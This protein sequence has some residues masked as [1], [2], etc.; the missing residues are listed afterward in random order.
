M[1][2]E[3]EM[4]MLQAKIQAG[5]VKEE[6]VGNASRFNDASAKHP[7]LPHF[8]DGID[9]LDIW[10]TRFERPDTEI[11]CDQPRRVFQNNARPKMEPVRLI[12]PEKKLN[13]GQRTGKAKVGVADKRLCFK[14]KKTGH[15]A[16]YCTAVDTTM[17]RAGAGVVLKATEVKTAG[18]KKPTEGSTMK[19]TDNLQSEVKDGMLQLASGKSVPVMMNCAALSDPE[20]TKSLRLPILRGEI[21]GREVDVMRDTGCEGVVVRRQLVDAGLLTGECCLLLTIDNTAL[22]AEKAV[23]N[24]RTPFL[25]GKVK[26]LCIPDAI[27]DVIVGNV[28]GARSPGDPEMSVMEPRE[29]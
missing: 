9:D 29:N 17:K 14:C 20:K 4:K 11:L 6:T 8:Q 19:V 18:V 16:R 5:I 10:L 22:L 1:R 28:D 12:E 21:G 13:S 2:L 26:A 3:T 24:L 23:I 15:I 27:C 7:K 25:S